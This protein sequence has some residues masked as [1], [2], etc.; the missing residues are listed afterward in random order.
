MVDHLHI[1]GHRHFSISW[2]LTG[3]LLAVDLF[4]IHDDLE[5]AAVTDDRLDVQTAAIFFRQLGHQTGGLWLVISLAAVSDLH[6]H[7]MSSV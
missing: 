7:E 5:N 1:N 2:K 4:A 6:F 3:F